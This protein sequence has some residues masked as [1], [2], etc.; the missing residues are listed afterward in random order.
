MTQDGT[1]PYHRSNMSVSCKKNGHDSQIYR[2]YCKASTPL[3]T[4]DVDMMLVSRRSTLCHSGTIL[5]LTRVNVWS[6]VKQD[7]FIGSL[8]G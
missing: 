4:P 6:K 5:I 3:Q 2:D 1:A 7:T 8:Y